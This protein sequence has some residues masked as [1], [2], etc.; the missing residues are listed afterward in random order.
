MY[1]RVDDN[2]QVPAKVR[3]LMREEEARGFNELVSDLSQN[4]IKLR[5]LYTEMLEK[6]LDDM[7]HREHWGRTLEWKMH[8]F[9]DEAREILVHWANMNKIPKTLLKKNGFFD[10]YANLYDTFEGILSS[11]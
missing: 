10:K 3:K 8:F 11:L 7:G 9:K 2:T 4:G 1:H 6:Q 5:A